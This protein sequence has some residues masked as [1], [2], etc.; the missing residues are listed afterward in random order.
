[1]K[2]KFDEL[3]EFPCRF[4]FKVVGYTDPKL[5]DNIMLVL[6]QHAPGEYS[7]KT[8]DSGKGTYQSVTIDVTVTSKEHV[9]TL[10]QALSEIDGVRMVM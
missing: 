8:K 7:P 2:T 9:E 4:P 6:Q 10:Y 1:M 5:V 3:L